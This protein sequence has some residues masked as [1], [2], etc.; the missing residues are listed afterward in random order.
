MKYTLLQM[1]Q[2]ILSNLSSDEVNSI[3]DSAESLQVA[4][5][6]RQKYF[7]IINRLDLPE[8]DQL[9]QLNPSLD[10]TVPVIMYVPDGINNIRWI[11]YFDSNISAAVNFTTSTSVNNAINGLGPSSSW[12]TTS[13]SS[14]TIASGQQTF[15]VGS[16]L[17]IKAGDKAVA[18]ASINPSNDNMTG[19]VTSYSGTVLVLNITATKGSGT[20]NSWSITKGT[21]VLSPPGYKYVTILPNDQFLDYMSGFNPS[22]FDVYRYTFQDTNNHFNGAYTF[23]YKNDLT[24]QYCTVL[25]NYYVI[26]DSYDSTVDSTLQAEKIMALGSVLPTFQMVD[27]FIPDLIEEQFPLLL[28]ESKA[29]AYY[30]LKQQPHALAAAEAQRGWS[31][32]QKQ[33]SVV[34]KPSYF[35]QT[36]NYGRK[37]MFSWRP[38]FKWH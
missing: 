6:I 26:F 4:T 34:N 20:F 17:Q 32:I 25:S 36:P 2:D 30:E 31:T 22:Q 19:T 5:I 28:N 3:S 12:S 37:S 35:D 10:P 29:L 23:Y 27:T 21:G 14:V 15:T 11:K 8:H 16:G 13:T 38:S 9:I 24:P 1:V 33:K 18:A 7:D